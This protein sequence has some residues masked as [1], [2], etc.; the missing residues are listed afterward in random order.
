MNKLLFLIF[1]ITVIT[2]SSCVLNDDGAIA[3]PTNLPPDIS[4]ES[5][6]DT[7]V[8]NTPTPMF[9]ATLTPTS[10][11]PLASNE[12]SPRVCTSPP[13][14]FNVR[15]VLDMSILNLRFE[16]EDMVT[17]EG[18]AEGPEPI[19]TP[20]TPEPTPATFPRPYIYTRRLLTGGQLSLL[21][22][23]LNPRPLDFA[24][25]FN[26]PCHES[27]PLEVISQSPNREWQLVQVHDWLVEVSGIWLV[28]RTEMVRLIPYIT[29]LQ[30]QWATDSSLLWIVYSDP[31]L[32]GYTLL[33][34]LDNQVSI[35]STGPITE[36]LPSV[37]NPWY[38]I[39][40]FSSSDKVVISTTSFEFP[41]LDS[42]EVF[43]INLTDSLTLTDSSRVIPGIVTVNWN[44]ATQSFLLEIVKES[45]IEIQDLSGNTL[46]VIPRST[47]A[48][49]HSIPDE[50][51]LEPYF[52]IGNGY[53]LSPS[54]EKFVIMQGSNLLLFECKRVTTP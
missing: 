52:R 18:W 49:F 29:H 44:D 16:N 6:T 24:P 47:L 21:N 25:P 38:Y 37:L 39:V 54:G 7:L 51:P 10:V 42:D 9:V 8:R 27:C 45:G 19:V 26:N 46:L 28:S 4:A 30:W 36:D 23:Q 3:N 50:G 34:D 11:T 33:V 31:E 43:T 2:L 13:Q 17:F 1:I 5:Q 14:Q 41:E 12:N 40:A 15:E 48:L 22:G 20:V 35:K 32:G 53:A